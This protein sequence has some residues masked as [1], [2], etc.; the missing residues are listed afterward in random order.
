M[1]QVTKITCD[2]CKK[3]LDKSDRAAWRIVVHCEPIPNDSGRQLL[4]LRPPPIPTALHFCDK[5]CLAKWSEQS[6]I[7]ASVQE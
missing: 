1:S 3:S 4:V 7:R 6:G 5:A 2:A